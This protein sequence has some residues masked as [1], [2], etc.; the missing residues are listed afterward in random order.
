MK[1]LELF[2]CFPLVKVG[3]DT[4]STSR[5]KRRVLRVADIVYICS[6]D[7]R[8]QGRIHQIYEALRIYDN[9]M[10]RREEPESALL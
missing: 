1:D 3:Q 10:R 2:C 5:T 6:P 9:S 7:L 8:K 4:I